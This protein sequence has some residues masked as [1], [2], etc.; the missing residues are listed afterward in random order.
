MSSI[1]VTTAPMFGLKQA[2]KLTIA[3]MMAKKKAEKKA[4][5]KAYDKKRF[6]A[7]KPYYDKKNAKSN[8]K[9]QQVS[10]EENE[11]RL[12]KMG[13]TSAED[14]IS[15]GEA[16]RIASELAMEPHAVL[17]GVSL[18]TFLKLAHSAGASIPDAQAF[19]FGY[20]GRNIKLEYLRWLSK[21][22]LCELDADGNIKE[23]GKIRLNRPVLLKSDGTVITQ[24]EAEDELGFKVLELYS[25]KLKLNS[26]RVECALQTHFQNLSLGVRLW[27]GPDK[28][29]KY[30]VKGDQL[31]VHK[32]FLTYSP[33]VAEMLRKGVIKVNY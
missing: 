20:T 19:Y 21:R 16:A 15:E 24:K 3:D 14:I 32:V 29:A 30:D 26:R 9:T 22:G 28:G 33:R 7:N 6:D 25:S 2:S 18:T 8:A 23:G 4:C 5:K 13:F 11:R 27:R 1:T 17:D 12:H 31:K 10:A